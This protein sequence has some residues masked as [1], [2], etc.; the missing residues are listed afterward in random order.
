MEVSKA[1]VKPMLLPRTLER[2]E[3]FQNCRSCGRIYWHGS[4]WTRLMDAVNAA[5]DEAR[6][7][8]A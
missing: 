6:D 3:H 5:L 7:I 1:A 4:H 8:V 2:Y